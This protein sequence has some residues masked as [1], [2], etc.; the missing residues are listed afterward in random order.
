MIAGRPAGTKTAAECGAH[1]HGTY[2]AYCRF[3]C[4]CPEAREDWRLYQKRRREGRHAPL[5]VDATGTRRRLAALMALG[6]TYPTIAAELGVYPSRVSQL[7]RTKQVHSVTAAAVTAVYDRL[8]T[9]R[10]PSERRAR[11][12]ARHGWP[13]PLG[14]DEDTIDDPA[15]TPVPGWNQPAAALPGIDW[16]AVER[17]CDGHPAAL[18]TDERVAAVNL[19]ARAGV[20]DVVIG[21]RLGVSADTVSGVRAR[22]GIP[23]GQ[24][25]ARADAPNWE[26]VARP[27]RRRRADRE[28]A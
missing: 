10:G 26:L 6:W 23:S 24:A 21:A 27:Y 19:M 11:M 8:S 28:A 20:L 1:R 16:V 22:H 13:P 9:R 2:S 5:Q 18:T 14:W 7:M 25:I 3:R 15:S 17:A 4:R 12:A